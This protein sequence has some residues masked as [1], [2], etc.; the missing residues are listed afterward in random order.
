V[1]EADALYRKAAGQ[2]W[3]A[4]QEKLEIVKTMGIP[5]AAIENIS[6]DDNSGATHIDE[7]PDGPKSSHPDH[8]EITV[9][10]EA[11]YRIVRQ[12]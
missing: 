5:A 7:I 9:T 1:R 4:V 11:T 10:L 12:P 2:A 8:V 6:Y 3:Q